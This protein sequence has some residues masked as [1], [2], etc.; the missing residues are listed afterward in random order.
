MVCKHSKKTQKTIRE[1]TNLQNELAQHLTPLVNLL[2]AARAVVELKLEDD[3]TQTKSVE[4]IELDEMTDD[5]Q[6]K[7]FEF[8]SV[9][10]EEVPEV[11]IKEKGTLEAMKDKLEKR[12]VETANIMVNLLDEVIKLSYLKYQGSVANY[13]YNEDVNQLRDEYQVYIN[14][15]DNKSLFINKL[16]KK[17]NTGSIDEVSKALTVL[18]QGDSITEKEIISSL[19]NNKNINL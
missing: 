10:R 17:A 14:K 19:K 9:F 13:K 6:K 4:K 5:M 12:D 7:L 15:L 16:L 18:G 3:L 2:R 1:N 8:T 11:G